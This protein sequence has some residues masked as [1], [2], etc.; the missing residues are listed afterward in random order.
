[1]IGRLSVLLYGS[2][3][4]LLF[5]ATFVYATLF[6]GGLL[7]PRT[8]DAGGAATPPLAAA[9]IDVALLGLFAVQ[10]TIMARPGFKARWTR[11][12]PAAAER[13]TFVLATCVCFGLLFWQWRPI[14]G[15]VWDVAHPAGRAALWITFALGMGTVLLST[16]LID[17]FELFGL[18]QAVEH[19]LRRPARRPSFQ[20]RSL[21][22]W[23]RHP[24]MLGFLVAFWSAPTM[25][26]GHLLFAGVVTAYVLVAVRVEERDLVRVHGDAYRAYQ[27]EVP[28]LLPWRRPRAEVVVAAAPAREPARAGS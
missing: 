6:V 17:H 25:T 10:H 2:T 14:D 15:V 7:V 26:T 28:M 8:V 24:L 20:L 12:I 23:V 13:S 5:L 18:R 4:Y 1:M 11:I 3:C 27:R 22:R 16:F 19:Y 21:Y 9:L